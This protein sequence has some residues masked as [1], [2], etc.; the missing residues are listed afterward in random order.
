MILPELTTCTKCPLHTNGFAVHGTGPVPAKTMII[1]EAPGED[2]NTEGAPFVGRSGRELDRLL[3]SGGVSRADAYITNVVKHWPGPGN[4]TPGVKIIRACK[5]W[6]LEEIALVDPEVIIAVGGIS[7]KALIPGVNLRKDHGVGQ[8]VEICGKVRTVYTVYHPAAGMHSPGLRPV[9]A[10]DYKGLNTPPVTAPR[11][12]YIHGEI[13]EPFDLNRPLALDIET[14]SLDV[15]S[16]DVVAIAYTQTIGAGW[17]GRPTARLLSKIIEFINKGGLIVV[18]NAQFDLTVLERYGVHAPNF[19]DTMLSGYVLGTAVGLKQRALNEHRVK[20]V[21]FDE[22][23]KGEKDSS[24]IDPSVLY[25]YAAVDV[26]QTVQFYHEDRREVDARGLQ[27][28]IKTEFDLVGV[29]RRMRRRGVRINEKLLDELSERVAVSVG[30]A[31]GDVYRSAGHEFN[32][33][34]GIQLGEIL[35]STMGLKPLKR[36]KGKTRWSVDEEVLKWLSVQYPENLLCQAVMHYRELAKIKGTYVDGLRSHIVD[37]RIH[38]ILK[39]TG[40]STFRFSAAEPNYQNQPSR[41]K[42]WKRLIKGLY[43]PSPGCRLVAIDY[44]QL[45]V[46]VAAAIS[47]DPVM[48]AVFDNDGDIHTKTVREIL[49]SEVDVSPEGMN[50]RTLAKNINFGS[51]YGLSG[52]GL[53]RYLASADPPIHISLQEAVEIVEGIRRTYPGYMAWVDGVKAFVREHGYA[54]TMMGRRKYFPVGDSTDTEKEWV[55]MP[56]QGTAVGDVVRDAM[57]AL[58]RDGFPLIINVH[59]ELVFDVDREE[60]LWVAREASEV[61]VKRAEDILG[62]RVKVSVSVGDSWGEMEEVDL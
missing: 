17:V 24:K 60:A 4:P 11:T 3:A 38:P 49:H 44:G 21:S 54:E 34:S 47:R 16:C 1:G 32:V 14:T 62:V 19:W 48:I 13:M 27:R 37:G 50:L 10:A 52:G 31:R 15:E 22:V 5:P 55:N 6:L 41:N 2:E 30:A 43:I 36:T 25:P 26:D 7:A 39:Q 42:T 40:A 51:L 59:D 46:R 20:M 9:I 23:G 33:D 58:G 56:I 45:E 57:W 28:V 29:I 53:K 35:F 8:R 18:H 12:V 61:M